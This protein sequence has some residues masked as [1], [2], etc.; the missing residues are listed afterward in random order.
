MPKHF[1][2]ICSAIDQLH[3]KLDFN[4]PSL[5]ETGL[6]QGLENHHLSQPDDDT[7]SMSKEY[8]RQSGIFD[9]HPLLQTRHSRDQGRQEAE[10]EK[11]TVRNSVCSTCSVWP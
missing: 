3:S 8:D 4:V 2:R 1:E 5:A 6:S 11:K 7:A 9:Q 10:E